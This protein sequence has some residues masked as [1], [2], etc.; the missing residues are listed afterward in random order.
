[1]KAGLIPD[2]REPSVLTVKQSQ[3]KEWK[4]V[5]LSLVNSVF[6]SDATR[7][8]QNPSRFLKGHKQMCVALTRGRYVGEEK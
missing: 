3:G 6:D 4:I 7:R 2:G 1:M 5:I 8:K